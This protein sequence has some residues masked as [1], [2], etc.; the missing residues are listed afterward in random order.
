MALRYWLVGGFCV[1]LLG[2]GN[3]S[4]KTNTGASDSASAAVDSST[5][6]N[7][8][9]DR[10]VDKHLPAQNLAVGITE[11]AESDDDLPG[12]ASFHEG[13]TEL[14][15]R[16]AELLQS[17]SP[18]PLEVDRWMNSQPLTLADLK[19]KVVVLDFWA[20]W[21]GPCIRSV[22]H[23]NEMVERFGDQVVIIGVCHTRGAEK[24]QETAEEHDIKYPIASDI[25]GNTVKSYQVNGY[26][27]YYLIDRNGKLRIADCK[28]SSVEA[29][30]EALLSEE[31]L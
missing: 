13:D 25:D 11:L 31:V 9:P 20:T 3:E 22:P 17:P 21:C 10:S 4:T 1:I 19:G 30:I 6:A 27:D 24:M 26:P 15:E 16:L 29:A 12:L 18:P 14:R 28:N 2:C 5:A 8:A 23:T 7:I